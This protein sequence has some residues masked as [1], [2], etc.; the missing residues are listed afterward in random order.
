L[1]R[2]KEA[3]RNMIFDSFTEKKDELIT[4]IVQRTEKNDV[5]VNIGKTEGVMNYMNQIPGEHY[6]SGM[7]VKV[8]INDVIRTTKGPQI[9]LSRSN[10]TFIKRLFELEIPEVYDG[11]VEIHSISRE[12]GSRTKIAVSSSQED[13]DAVGAC[14]GHKGTRIQNIL[15]E[16]GA[17]RIDVAEYSDDPVEYIQNALKPAST[18]FVEIDEESKA[19]LVVV[20]DSQLSLAIGKDGQNVRLAARLTGWK[21]DIKNEEQY[22]MMTQ[23]KEAAAD[24]SQVDSVE[25]E[26]ARQQS[27]PM[28]GSFADGGQVVGEPESGKEDAIEGMM[29]EAAEQEQI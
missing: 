2:I 20:D 15:N 17:E 7:R 18:L 3:E 9:L 19:A 29:P 13:I 6:Y 11:T 10:P 21:I 23:G 24:E 12:A 22:Q 4:G 14:V 1:Q 16:I 28:E 25:T 5:Y 27:E 26:S 8:Y